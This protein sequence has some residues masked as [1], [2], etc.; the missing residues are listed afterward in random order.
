VLDERITRLTPKA[1]P[2]L[3]RAGVRVTT[4]PLVRAQVSAAI[5][6]LGVR[7]RAV[8]ATY[9]EGFL[10]GWG[11][12]VVS[13]LYGTD[14]YVAGAELMGLSARYLRRLERRALARAGVV[15]AVSPQLAGRWSALG[16]NPVVIPNGCWPRGPGEAARASEP[17]PSAVRSLP[18]PVAGLVGQ[19]SDRIDLA[20]LESVAAAGYSLLLV[21]PLDP[22]WGGARF[23]ALIGQPHVHY[24]GPV[25]GAAVPG[26]LAAIDVGLTPYCDSA[27][28]RASFPLK[29]LEYLGAGIPVVSA[30]LPTARWLHAELAQS[31]PGEPDEVM[32]L[33]SGPAEFAARV[34][35]ITRARSTA[36]G[37]AAGDAGPQAARCAAFAAQH[38]WPRRARA[39]A[40][41]IG[42]D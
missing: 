31:D 11:D 20:V 30:D 24:A 38:S 40:A 12:G 36:G 18:R 41:E 15:A 8:V 7:P 2:G 35:G 13:V 22:R 5:R 10:G 19:L 6:R 37:P 42:V 17:V 16:A 39:L 14:D 29:T 32:A 21:G 4:G 27:F 1:L 23:Q 3:T 26:Y 33:A 9:L 34:A 25:P 28:N